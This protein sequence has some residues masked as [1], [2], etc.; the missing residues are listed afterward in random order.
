M[1][2]RTT[3][4]SKL[5]P[6]WI[7]RNTLNLWRTN[8][9]GPAGLQAHVGASR[10]PRSASIKGRNSKWWIVTSSNYS[11]GKTLFVLSAG[12]THG[13]IYV[14]ADPRVVQL[15]NYSSPSVAVLRFTGV[16]AGFSLNL[17]KLALPWLPDISY[18]RAD[19]PSSGEITIGPTCSKDDLELDDLTG[20][21]VI[22]VISAGLVAGA[23]AT[24]I[25][26]G[27]TTTAIPHI[28]KAIG[29]IFG[30]GASTPGIGA[31]DYVC[32]M[33]IKDRNLESLESREIPIEKVNR[34]PK[35]QNIPVAL[36]L[37]SDSLFDFASAKLTTAA[38]ASLEQAI[39]L[40]VKQRVRSVLIEGHTDSK[41][42][43]EYNQR[44][45]KARAIAVKDW[46]IQRRVPNASDFSTAGMGATEPI[47]PN[48][49]ADGA[50][51]PEGRRL[52]RRVTIVLAP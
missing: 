38:A 52:N 26:F 42:K 17:K 16:G 40:I 15:G 33:S 32:Y 30:I 31:I 45:S 6:D 41:G 39:Q 7:D 21:C 23:G 10:M 4:I 28:C 13:D 19:M 22:R 43:P 29:R 3:C 44:L 1:T 48:S 18:S 12:G 50:D 2:H 49:K 14:S 24:F 34:P 46:F 37:P 5:G 25:F 36:T 51:N 27:P 20:W 47:A 35:F 11:V 8:A 9:P